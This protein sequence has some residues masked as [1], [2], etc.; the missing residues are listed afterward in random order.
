[1]KTSFFAMCF[2][3]ATSAFG[4]SIAG[5]N[6]LNSQPVVYEFTSHTQKATHKDMLV[7]ESLLENS[8]TTYAKGERPLWEVAPQHVYVPLGDIARELRKEHDLAKKSETVWTN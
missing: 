6:V 7:E 5:G 1:M 4:Q 3:F 2:L 8:P